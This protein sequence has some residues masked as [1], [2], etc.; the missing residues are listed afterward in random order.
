LSQV[1]KRV[2]A[3][4]GLAV[5]AHVDRPSFSLLANLGFV[6]SDL[7]VPALE[8]SRLTDPAEAVARW[9]DL[10]HWPLIRGSDTHRLSELAPSLRLYLDDTTLAEMA[11]ALAGQNGR[12][13]A[14]LP[15]NP[16]DDCYRA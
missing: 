10:G 15:R 1:I 13:F 16:V 9:P 5:P 8:I 3:L 12:R 11:L 4:G 6:P 7:Q 2:Q 14:V